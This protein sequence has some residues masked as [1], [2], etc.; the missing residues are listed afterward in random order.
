M[1]D[2][3]RKRVSRKKGVVEKQVK[4][5]LSAPSPRKYRRELRHDV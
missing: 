3:N 5:G 4:P 1:R 2:S